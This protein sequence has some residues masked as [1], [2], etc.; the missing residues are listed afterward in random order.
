MRQP[1]ILQQ[2]PPRL[3]LLAARAW[4]LMQDMRLQQLLHSE[5]EAGKAESALL[6]RVV[7]QE[8]G[9]VLLPAVLARWESQD[10]RISFQGRA[11]LSNTAMAATEKPL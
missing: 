3:Q 6:L 10:R 7:A 9:P 8:P 11:S 1:L 2:L 4:A 5:G